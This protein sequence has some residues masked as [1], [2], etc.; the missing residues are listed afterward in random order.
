MI[1]QRLAAV[2]LL[3]AAAPATARDVPDN[4]EQFYRNITSQ[5]KCSDTLAS[6]FYS[7][8]GTS[9]YCGD[10][11]QDYG[12]IYLKGEGKNLV[13]M[14]IDC[15]GA[16]KGSPADDGRCRASDDT[17]SVS[18]F[19][20]TIGTYGAGIKDIDAYVHPY[21]VFGNTGSKK[22][23][24]TF[25]PTQ[26]GIEPLSLMAVVYGIWADENG[27]DGD[28][29]MVGEAS[30]SLATACYGKNKVDGNTG[31]DDDDV[32]YIAFLGKDAVPGATG[33]DWNA[34]SY[35]EFQSSVQGLGDKLIERIGSS[36]G[37]WSAGGDGNDDS[38]ARFVGSPSLA[39]SVA[40][41]LLVGISLV[42]T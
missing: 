38:S 42:F 26:H 10:H 12:V 37:N 33:A 3:A 19:Q 41:S 1:S 2:A 20:D 22:D 34:T 21:V 8:D 32:L 13:N 14:D 35:D 29:P 40:A 27:D 31:H 7:K 39:A 16:Q 17:L 15:D 6:G 30:I 5:N 23:W 36:G 11:L 25:S 24:A 9:V 4:I 28:K 18:S